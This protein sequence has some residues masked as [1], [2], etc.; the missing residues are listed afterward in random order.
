MAIMCMVRAI[1]LNMRVAQLCVTDLSCD[2]Q[3][4]TCRHVST[5]RYDA[6]SPHV[7]LSMDSTL[8]GSR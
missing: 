5:D 3:T 4:R 8:A 2:E 6:E 1:T 7:T